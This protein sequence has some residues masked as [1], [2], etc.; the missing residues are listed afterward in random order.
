MKLYGELKN[1]KYPN[2][3]KCTT[4]DLKAISQFHKIAINYIKLKRINHEKTG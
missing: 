3:S 1:G 4:K 2:L